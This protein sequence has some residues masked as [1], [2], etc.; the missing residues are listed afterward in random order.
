[1]TPITIPVSRA[2]GDSSKV[3]TFELP[4]SFLTQARN[5]GGLNIPQITNEQGETVPDPSYKV[6]LYGVRPV[7]LGESIKDYIGA[8]APL[9]SPENIDTYKPIGTPLSGQDTVTGRSYTIQH[10]AV[11][12][13][14]ANTDQG[15]EN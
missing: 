8:T 4:T 11:E 12:N 13:L 7:P 9:E 5:L 2:E 3:A 6:Y 14:I 10:I 15:A 1:M